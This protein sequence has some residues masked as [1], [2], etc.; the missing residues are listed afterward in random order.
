MVDSLARGQWMMSQ[1]ADLGIPGDGWDARV[2]AQLV[3]SLLRSIPERAP[4]KLADEYADRLTDSELTGEQATKLLRDFKE[5]VEV[6]VREQ[7]DA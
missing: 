6:Y 4:G 7:S 5:A 3:G 2:A 1:L